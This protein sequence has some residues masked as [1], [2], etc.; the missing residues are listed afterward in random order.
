MLDVGPVEVG[1][2]GNG[3]HGFVGRGPEERV[4]RGREDG[5]LAQRDGMRHADVALCV[6]ELVVLDADHDAG[7]VLVRVRDPRV[8]GLERL[9]VDVGVDAAVAREQDVAEEVG[10]HDGRLELLERVHYVWPVSVEV[11]EDV[12][13]LN[14]LDEAVLMVW[15]EFCPGVDCWLEV[16]VY[17][18][19]V[20]E[21][22]PDVLRDTGKL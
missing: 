5:P 2:T 13:C 3:E 19:L 12:G 21:D 14:R 1:Q 7:E 15:V 16:W 6:G 8:D 18:P 4:V 11:E 17:L 10:A 22:V 20:E 9:G